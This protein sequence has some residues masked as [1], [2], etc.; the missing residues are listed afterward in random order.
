MKS[1][2]T[3][4]HHGLYLALIISAFFP[5]SSRA[6]NIIWNIGSGT[7]DTSTA[8]WSGDSTTF[9]DGGVDNVTFNHTVANTRTITIA[10]GMTPL[11]TTVN[12]TG[13]Q[14]SKYVFSGVAG[15]IDGGTLI[16][17]GN[18]ELQISTASLLS[19]VALVVNNGT[20]WLSTQ[21]TVNSL[22]GTGG[23]MNISGGGI[24]IGGDNSS[25]GWTGTTSGHGSFTKNGTGTFT[26]TGSGTGTSFGPSA[27]FTINAGT[28]RLGAS[29][30][31]VD[32]T[33][34]NLN[35]NATFDLN[36]FNETLGTI[37]MQ[38]GSV[39]EGNGGTLTLSSTYWPIL[40]GT[41]TQGQV[42]ANVHFSSGS[43]V[44]LRV[45]NNASAQAMTQIIN[46]SISG[47]SGGLGS[48]GN[49]HSTA[50]L[51]LSGSSANTFTG[52]FRYDRGTIELNKPD[53]VNAIP[54]NVLF[55]NGGTIKWLASNQI[56]DSA[57]L[58]INSGNINLNGFNET[59]ARLSSSGSG[60]FD[61]SGNGLLTLAAASGD[62]ISFGTGSN[63]TKRLG[64][65]V[66]L[67]GNGGD[68]LFTAAANQNRVMQIGTDT[69]GQRSMDI[70][71]ASR[72]ITVTDGPLAEDA[73]ITSIISG[74]GSINKAGAGTLQLSAANTFNGDTRIDAG[75][76]RLSHNLA[77]QNS[78]LDT[79]GAG[80]V[81]LTGFTTPTFGGLK[82]GTNL[83]SAIASG[84]ANV[85]SLTLN[86][87]AGKSPSY[88][89]SIAN[90]AANMS[91]IKTGAGV[92]ILGGALTHSGPT[93]ILNGGLMIN[94][95]ITNSTITIGNGAFLGGTGLISTP[96]T[97]GNG[98]ILA[99]GNSPGTLF[100]TT[101]TWAGAG[102][103]EWEINN[104]LNSQGSDP[105]WD[106]LNLSGALTVSA[107]SGNQYILQILGLDNLNAAGLV[108]NFDGTQSYTWN[109]A[110]AGGGILG[111]N[112]NAFQIDTAGF[113]N[114]LLG[115]QFSIGQAGNNVQLSFT[116]AIVIP[117]PSRSI[118]LLT[119]LS[120]ILCIRSR[121]ALPIS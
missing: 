55:V 10:A 61:P 33:N 69:A 22:S 25:T 67:S 66:A 24:T 40:G 41:G 6:A 119:A 108:G 120:S 59:V 32:S 62:V 82:G 53:G 11:S 52:E 103:Y 2:S 28:F 38:G 18:G 101:A 46:G 74:A 109:I 87:G 47:A 51:R 50:I 104:A 9:T 63:I 45:S 16:K 1:T 98:A 115:G 71:S 81:N 60:Q 110:T 78:A 121:K 107:N 13:G 26:F 4:L 48:D 65:N 8:N 70:G 44:N 20:L 84:Y 106:F 14:Y 79:S 116:P 12:P 90:G 92:Q 19:N 49:T 68:L 80:A 27:G 54:T 100:G 111:F 86:P 31:I 105:G 7:W 5:T 96:F 35:N 43:Q 34:L 21:Q 75:V 89:G 37:N 15:S 36:G 42:N 113:T 93:S 94:G 91:L 97:I 39:I 73:R 83:A 58:A 30:K 57:S 64:I 76:L 118:F 102:I 99:P 23:T 72:M 95:S 17:N 85:T 112:A 56:S 77:L 114:P 117:E 29:D 88:S 3:I